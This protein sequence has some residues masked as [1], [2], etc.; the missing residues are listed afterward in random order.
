[1]EKINL[2]IKQTFKVVTINKKDIRIPKLGLKHHLIISNSKTLEDGMKQIIKS[3]HSNLSLSERD[4]VT[5]H[6]LAY[7]GKMKNSAVVDGKTY[8]LD[9]I[10]I[11]QQLEFKTN[12][13][14][15][16]KFKTPNFNNES[17][18]AISDILNNNCI[19]VTSPEGEQL[20]IP[21]FLEM[22][23]YVYKWVEK[24]TDTISLKTEFGEIKGIQN[25]M[26]VFN[27]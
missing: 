26:E 19:K 21:D 22:P 7:N 23:A 2:N 20:P 18:P 17:S 4:L 3:I 24:I 25:L 27:E 8:T 12:N 16:Y 6:L 1:M 5:L 15:V 13:G 9:D 11:C 14:I 10:T